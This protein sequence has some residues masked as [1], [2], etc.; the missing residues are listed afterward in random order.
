MPSSLTLIGPVVKGAN[1]GFYQ[2]FDSPEEINTKYR[3][4]VV[5][6]VYVEAAT[7]AGTS[8][9]AEETPDEE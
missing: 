7:P 9:K 5:N 8:E 4:G 6:F 2:G 3:P 1:E